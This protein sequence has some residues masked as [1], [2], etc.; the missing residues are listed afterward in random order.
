MIGCG[1]CDPWFNPRLDY[2]C[3]WWPW[4]ASAHYSVHSSSGCCCHDIDDRYVFV[5][6]RTFFAEP[7]TG[8]AG[9]GIGIAVPGVHHRCRLT[10]LVG[11]DHTRRGHCLHLARDRQTEIEQPPSRRRNVQARLR[12]WCW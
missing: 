2:L 12:S 7:R 4:L 11:D 5:P 1:A 10:P 3:S 8:V 6:V 9:A